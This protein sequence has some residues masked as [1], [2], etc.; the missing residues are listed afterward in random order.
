MRLDRPLVARAERLDAGRGLDVAGLAE[1]L[2]AH[3]RCGANVFVKLLL[4]GQ[5][6]RCCPFCLQ[7]AG[8][9]D[10]APFAVGDDR[11][12]ITHA[13]GA[14]TARQSLERIGVDREQVGADCRRPHRPRVQHAGHA[15]ILHVGEASGHLVRDVL[16]PGRL[17]D[18]GE[19]R[20]LLERRLGIAGKTE[21]P[22]TDQRGV[23]HLAGRIG[24]QADRAVCRLDTVEGSLEPVGAELQQCL[25]RGRGGAADLHA[26][27][28][29]ALAAAGRSLIGGQGGVAGNDIDAIEG[30]AELLR[31][32]LAQRRRQALSEVDLAAEQRHPAI[33]ADLDEAVD[34]ARNQRPG[35][36]KAHPVRRRRNAGRRGRAAEGEADDES[37]GALQEFAARRD[38]EGH[39]NL[40][41]SGHFIVT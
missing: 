3:H 36:R 14:R 34:R 16:A 13:H 10:G 41:R 27:G 26:A 24:A 38:G 25:A 23:A 31:R 22:V 17:A 33:S 40:L 2:V 4:F 29:D 30:Y 18:H 15:D 8:A 11:Q 5:R 19:F 39:G 28:L 32:H 6:R 7:F 21:T 9:A 35:R 20:R 37:A 1:H 12:E